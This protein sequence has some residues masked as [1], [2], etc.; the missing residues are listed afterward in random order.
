MEKILNSLDLIIYGDDLIENKIYLN[1]NELLYRFSQINFDQIYVDSIFFI[2]INN[3]FFNSKEF[4]VNYNDSVYASFFEYANKLNIP[5]IYNGYHLK[6]LL[7]NIAYNFSKCSIPFNMVFSLE[8]W[9]QTN[10]LQNIDSYHIFKY[11]KFTSFKLMQFNNFFSSF[12]SL[13]DEFKDYNEYYVLFR[14]FMHYC[15]LYLNSKDVS[16]LFENKL[17]FYLIKHKIASKYLDLNFYTIKLFVH[18]VL[19]IINR[20]IDENKKIPKTKFEEFVNS[21]NTLNVYSFDNK[22]NEYT[23]LP[24]EDLIEFDGNKYSLLWTEQIKNDTYKDEFS[25]LFGQ[26]HIENNVYESSINE[27]IENDNSLINENNYDYETLENFEQNANNNFESY[28]NYNN[29]FINNE[30]EI[31][32]IND[33]RLYQIDVDVYNANGFN[34]KNSEQN[35]NNIEDHSFDLEKQYIGNNS[36]EEN[37]IENNEDIYDDGKSNNDYYDETYKKINDDNFSIFDNLG[38]D[39]E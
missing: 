36:S 29:D 27:V 34:N 23:L 1:K 16:F 6:S 25:K 22:N 31:V 12:K 26:Y 5:L 15:Q 35:L 32:D 38:D 8:K 7:L 2:K 24:R 19:L 4:N 28:D 10:K 18:H 11:Q 21:F 33:E 3:I 39:D 20:L 17:N 13:F 37:L 9:N 14:L 30:D